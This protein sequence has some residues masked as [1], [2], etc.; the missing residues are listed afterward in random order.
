M[1]YS[2]NTLALSER[3]NTFTLSL[4]KKK[5]KKLPPY[6][7]TPETTKTKAETFILLEIFQVLQ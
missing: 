3:K 7:P 2:T 1:V 4:K 6:H 5:K